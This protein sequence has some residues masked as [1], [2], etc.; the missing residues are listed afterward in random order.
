MK[1]LLII[2]AGGH[3]QVVKEIAEDL[4]YTKIAFLDDNSPL[5]IGKIDD[6]EK[7]KDEYEEAF[8]GIGNNAFRGK[9]IDRLV[10]AGYIVPALVHPSAYV[11]RTAVIEIGTV[12]EPKAIVNA[13][14]NV[15]KGCIVSVGAIV[16]HDTVLEECVHANAGSIV[17]AGGQVEKE[18]KLQAGE[19]VLGY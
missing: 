1:S 15:G 6:I 7:L 9:L 16:D 13:H 10:Q 17:K 18:R 2:G 11:S 14:A 19:V 8:V 4:G 5:A 12:V 3:G